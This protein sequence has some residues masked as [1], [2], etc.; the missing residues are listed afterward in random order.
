[1]VGASLTIHGA[2][3]GGTDYFGTISAFTNSSHVTISP[4]AGTTVTTSQYWLG[5]CQAGGNLTNQMSMVVPGSISA[6]DLLVLGLNTSAPITIVSVTDSVGNVWVPHGPG[7]TAI[8]GIVFQQGYACLNAVSANAGM[9]ITITYSG[10]PTAQLSSATLVEFSGGPWEQS[11]LYAVGNST[12]IN[13]L[14]G[15]LS[16][17]SSNGVIVA[18]CEVGNN[19]TAAGQTAGYTRLPSNAQQNKLNI[20]VDGFGSIQEYQIFTKPQINTNI[21]IVQT[22]PASGYGITVAAFAPVRHIRAKMQPIGL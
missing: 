9:V 5:N 12:A 11:G 1:M 14:A 7:I 18:F 4:N 17:T 19:V 22:A 3:A 6:G 15:P 2:G 8:S 13:C 16:L 20:N 21:V 10:T